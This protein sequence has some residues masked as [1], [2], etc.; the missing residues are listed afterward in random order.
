MANGWGNN[1]QWQILFFGLSSQSYGFSRP[2][3]WMWELDHKEGWALKNWC[4]WTMVL[5]KTL[6]RVPWTARRSN[7]SVLKE[8][9]PEYSLEGLMLK[10]KLQYFGHLMWRTDSLE[11]TLM[12]GRLKAGG[13]G[14]QRMR[15][16]GGI[17]NSVDMSL[18]KFPELVM[19]REAWHAAV[20][21]VTKSWTQLSNWTDWRV[22]IYLNIYIYIYI[23][24]YVICFYHVLC[25][26]AQSCPTLCNPMDCSPQ[27]SSVHGIFQARIL[28]WVAI[29]SSRWSSWPRDWICV[30]CVSRIGRQILYQNCYLGS[31]YFLKNSDII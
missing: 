21:G 23:Y 10:L 18:S 17:T 30:S 2:H 28:E 29:F 14:W 13:E 16:L 4:F 3:V 12:L 25:Q 24:I 6:L 19:D 8:I 26:C 1:E 11:K 31:P 20:H 9:S 7:Q 27:V 5:K 22:C 15:W